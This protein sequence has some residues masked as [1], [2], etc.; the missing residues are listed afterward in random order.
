MAFKSGDHLD[1]RV[2]DEPTQR[3]IDD[4]R[5]SKDP[6]AA[7]SRKPL[8][9]ILDLNLLYSRTSGV[10]GAKRKAI[11]L[12]EQVIGKSGDESGA[13]LYK[14]KTDLAFQHVFAAL[15]PEQIEQLVWLNTEL[16]EE[17]SGES[18]IYKIWHDHDVEKLDKSVST[19]KADA[20]LVSF[21]ASGKG[22]CWAVIDSGIDGD[23]VHFREHDN[24]SLP[25]QIRHVD[26]TGDDV[27]V[28]RKRETPTDE[29]GHGTH[30]AGIIG[31]ESVADVATVER[32]RDEHDD[33][34]Y[35]KSVVTGGI[36]GVAPQCTLVSLRVLDKDGKGKV[37]SLIAALGYIS[38]VN[39]DGRWRFIHGVNMSVGYEF[40]A[41]W[42]ACGQSP[43]CVE[44]D[45]LSRSGVLVVVAAGNSGYGYAQTESEGSFKTG[46]DVTINDPG[47]AQSAIT[48]GAT[49][50]EK[51]HTYGVSYFSSKGPTGDGR[52][53]PDLV[54]PGEKVVSCA[55]GIAKQDLVRDS[56]ISDFE[57]RE[58]SGTSMAAPHVSGAMAA[59]LSIRKEFIGQPERVKEIFLES[60]TD[61]G[62]VP[63]FQGKGLI[64]L[65]R[66]I[67]SI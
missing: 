17:R 1:K 20:A 10:E 31:G 27:R 44:V 54:A 42:Y 35:Q 12:V 45:R 47:N 48:V 4:A 8:E 67:Q 13:R 58:E 22:V 63:A 46:L 2:I 55:A 61:L 50:K 49:H 51:P 19:I 16:G 30:V 40:D 41:E 43:L 59:F 14:N 57:Y 23:H 7:I 64:D 24:L 39:S 26:F 38:K 15:T 60:C 28:M 21:S 37:S 66:A 52:L 65:M 11:D 18:P 29:N 56:D 9:V 53:K 25:D 6:R 32:H 33:C 3:L 62:R 36:R 34:F 5:K